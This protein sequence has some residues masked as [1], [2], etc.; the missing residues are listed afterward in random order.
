MTAKDQDRVSKLV[1]YTK[2]NGLVAGVERAERD[3]NVITKPEKAEARAQLLEQHGLAAL[4]RPFR[5]RA[6]WLAL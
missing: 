1:D 2:S 6:T 3:A 4:A 5:A